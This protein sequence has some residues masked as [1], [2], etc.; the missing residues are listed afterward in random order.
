MK[1]LTISL[2]LFLQGVLWFEGT[3]AQ[4]SIRDESIT[5]QQQRMVFRQWDS[6]KFTPKSGLLGLNPYYWLV[7]GLHPNY[8][9]TDLRPLSLSGPQTQRI[10]FSGLM[11]ATDKNYERS[12]DTIGT[13]AREEVIAYSPLLSDSDPLW[14]LYYKKQ[15]KPVYDFDAAT[16]LGALTPTQ[17]MQLLGDGNFAWYQAEM[18]MLRERLMGSRTAIQERGARILSYY[19]MLEEY[20]K[21]QGSWKR[22]VNGVM[23]EVKHSEV[24]SK[25]KIGDFVVPGWNSKSDVQIAKEVLRN[26]KY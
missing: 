15:L 5:Y 1:K 3:L 23:G 9:K 24:R 22:K 7:W 16:A 2:M 26:R 14:L 21:L 10:A 17:R 6:D 25:L 12:S 19:R 18:E 20:R 4:K 11:S 8:P 13:A